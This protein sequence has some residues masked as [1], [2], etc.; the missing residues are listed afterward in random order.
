MNTPRIIPSFGAVLLA[1]LPL[2]VLHAGDD[3]TPA[4]PAPTSP[5]AQMNDYLHVQKITH[6]L[7]TTGGDFK[8]DGAEMLMVKIYGVTGDTQQDSICTAL[9]ATARK[10]RVKETVVLFFTQAAPAGGPGSFQAS[11]LPGGNGEPDFA[12][13]AQQTGYRLQRTVK[14]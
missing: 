7:E 9:A 1:A 6:T 14:L 2:A 4:H 8:G 10:S 13:D 11:H 3:A 12:R 5:S